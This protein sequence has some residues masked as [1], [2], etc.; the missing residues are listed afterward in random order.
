MKKIIIVIDLFKGCLILVEVGKVVE[1]GIKSINF[2]CYILVI[3][4]VDGGEG[5]LDVFIIVIKGKY[6]ILLVYGLLMKM[7]KIYYGLFGNGRIVIIEMVVISGLFF[8]FI[9]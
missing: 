5:L 8:V 6:I 7:V 2:F 3:F 1:K 9:E 4:I